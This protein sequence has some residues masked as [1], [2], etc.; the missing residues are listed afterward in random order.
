MT[1]RENLLAEIAIGKK[2]RSELGSLNA[3]IDKAENLLKKNTANAA[4]V[5]PEAK[6]TIAGLER[7]LATAE[8]FLVQLKEQKPDVLYAF[9]L[10]EAEQICGGIH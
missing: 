10:S 7:Q 8:Q 3:E 6:A 9:L 2:D 5:V 4:K 1:Q